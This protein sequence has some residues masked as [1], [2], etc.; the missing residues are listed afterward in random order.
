MVALSPTA[1]ARHAKTTRAQEDVAQQIE[2]LTAII[3]KLLSRGPAAARTSMHVESE[4]PVGA[5]HRNERAQGLA[6]R[7]LWA[8]APQGRGCWPRGCQ[9]T[10]ADL[11]CGGSRRA[12]APYG[13][14]LQRL[15][16]LGLRARGRG[17]LSGGHS[18]SRYCG[19]QSR[20]RPTGVRAQAGFPAPPG[21]RLLR[22]VGKLLCRSA[23]ACS[24]A[25]RAPTAQ[26]IRHTHCVPKAEGG[27][28]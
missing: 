16:G 12:Q 20:P 26:R 21:T 7:A 3:A 1:F 9:R 28:R 14:S 8:A 19:E 22:L 15:P 11:S 17:S 2:D 27:R 4:T 13:S 24:K 18:Q 25:E 10:P 5:P 23:G 6:R